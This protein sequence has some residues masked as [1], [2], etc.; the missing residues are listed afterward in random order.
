MRLSLLT[1]ALLTFA[2]APEAQVRQGLLELGG[3]ASLESLDAGDDRLT[4]L[5]F[6]PVV[7]YFFTDALEA[8]VGLSYVKVED[9][10]GSGFINLF[11][12][13]H[14]A[15]RGQTT[16]PYLKAQIGTS[17][18]DDSDLQ[19]GGSGGAKFFFLPGGALTG[20]VFL[21]TDG[22]AL[23]VG[24]QAGVSIFL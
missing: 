19:F 2:A 14:F 16:V 20:E 6:S 8:G 10:D 22:D 13:Y 15:R 12:A 17:F 9:V 5:Q 24:A 3:S 21:L 18:T 11:G 7:G 1:L 4:V 23:N